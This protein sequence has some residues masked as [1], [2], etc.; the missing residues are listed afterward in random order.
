MAIIVQYT[1]WM[2]NRITDEE[3]QQFRRA[4]QNV[5]PMQPDGRY[6]APSRQIPLP[7]K[8]PKMAEAPELNIHYHSD[9]REWLDPEQQL[10]FHRTGI[11]LKTLQQLKSGKLAIGGKLDLHGLTVDGA[12]EALEHFLNRMH[13]ADKRLVIVIH[14][15]GKWQGMAGPVLKSLCNE[16]LRE[17]RL[18][19]AFETA[20]PKHGGAGALYVL[21]RRLR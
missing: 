2:S 6:Q 12:R 4:M 17:H 20:Q 8:K 16:W 5:K 13:Q 9:P 10:S 15:K 21:L 18:V 14:G 19:L 1:L 3:Q 11:K 7:S